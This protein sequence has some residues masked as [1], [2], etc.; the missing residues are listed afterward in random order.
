M[1]LDAVQGDGRDIVL[2]LVGCTHFAVADVKEE[3]GYRVRPKSNLVGLG[4]EHNVQG[5]LVGYTG[6][7]EGYLEEKGE[8]EG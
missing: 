1:Q 7:E 3:A 5:V 6:E 4:E 8:G 2:V